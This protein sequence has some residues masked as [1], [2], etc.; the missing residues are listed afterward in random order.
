VSHRANGDLV[1]IGDLGDDRNMLFF[2]SINGVFSHQGHCL[3]AADQFTC[4]DMQNF[5]DVAAKG[6]LV[7]FIFLGHGVFSSFGNDIVLFFGGAECRK[8]MDTP[9]TGII[10][11]KQ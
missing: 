3:A 2:G 4:S 5:D 9:N 10:T 11:T 8:G 6:A 7:H 1:A